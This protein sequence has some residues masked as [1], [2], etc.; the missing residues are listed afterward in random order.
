[1]EER[2]STGIPGLDQL[3]EGGLPQGSVTLVSGDAGTGKTVFCSQFL[4][5]G[6]QQN[7]NGLFVTME[8]EPVEIQRDAASFGWTF[9]KYE[10]AGYLKIAYTNPFL[11][12]IG[13]IRRTIQSAID[14]VDAARVAV[15]ST[16]ILGMY[17]ENLSKV[18]ERIYETASALK[19]KNCTS[20]MTS[21][22]PEGDKG[23][24]RYSVEEFVA[25]GVILLKGPQLGDISRQLMV[26]KMRRTQI[27]DGTYDLV[28]TGDGIEVS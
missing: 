3:I 12:D 25:D 20:L 6:L 13:D 27:D 11:H 5:N 1:M 2:V 24:S 7:Q 10:T 16:S 23:V 19:Q 9:E 22:I 21:E 8:E 17:S 15:D 14:E 18:R 4:W 26:K 28:F